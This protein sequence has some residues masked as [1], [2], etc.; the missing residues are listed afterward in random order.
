MVKK[1]SGKLKIKGVNPSHFD[2]SQLKIYFYVIPIVIVM[3]LPII[4]IFVNAF[5]PMDELFPYPPRLFVRHPTLQNFKDLFA[6]SLATDVPASRYL[7]NTIISTVLTVALTLFISVAAGYVFS[8]KRSKSV[9]FLFG[10]NSLA[11]MFVTTAVAIPRYFVIVYSGLIDSFLA[12]IIPLLVTPV[13]VFLVKQF[14]DQL[15]NALIEAAEIDGA[16]DF[17]ILRKIIMPLVK[18]TMATLTIL[19]F[20]SAWNSTEASSFYLNDES[21]KTFAFYMSN[22]STGNGVAGQGI[23]AAAT[24]IMFLPNLILFIILQSKVM[25]TMAFSGIK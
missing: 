2:T 6:V 19:T 11:L 3:L 9:A 7:V 5:K 23:G 13:G 15:P 1:R 17:Q 25:N 12:N 14:I 21:L 20:Q 4:F 8:K 22:L 16:S 18:P 24:L 10:V